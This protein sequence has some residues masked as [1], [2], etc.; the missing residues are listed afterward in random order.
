[1]EDKNREL[2][3]KELE[4][5]NKFMKVLDDLD[6][7]TCVRF[8]KQCEGT[9]MVITEL[10]GVVSDLVE[11]LIEINEYPNGYADFIKEVEANDFTLTHKKKGIETSE[12]TI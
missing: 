5:F 2:T 9:D 3:G 8:I 7:N 10:Q 1:M 4:D 12:E 11:I 6:F